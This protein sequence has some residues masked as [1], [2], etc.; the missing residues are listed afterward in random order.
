MPLEETCKIMGT[1]LEQCGKVA[2]KSKG[3]AKV[4]L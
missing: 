2:K 3:Y 4:V 1:I